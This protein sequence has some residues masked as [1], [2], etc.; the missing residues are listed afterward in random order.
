MWG[1]EVVC[2]APG[3]GGG[4]GVDAGGA[5]VG[6]LVLV[7]AVAWWLALVLA[8]FYAALRVLARVGS[9]CTRPTCSLS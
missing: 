8:V 3:G 4:K 2:G 1:A 9:K 5:V 6:A 7:A